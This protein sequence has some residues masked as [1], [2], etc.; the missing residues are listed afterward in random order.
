MSV[1][2]LY[3]ICGVTTAKAWLP[4]V[5]IGRAEWSSSGQIF[6]TGQRHFF[7]VILTIILL[8]LYHYCLLN[9]RIIKLQTEPTLWLLTV[10]IADNIDVLVA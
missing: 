5:G 9:F 4:T 8:F 7:A 1:G 6:D 3:Q 10:S 2:S